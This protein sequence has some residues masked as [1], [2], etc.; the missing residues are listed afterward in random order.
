MNSSFASVTSADGS[1]SKRTTSSARRNRYSS[2]SVVPNA[3][4]TSAHYLFTLLLC[5]LSL[6]VAAVAIF[7]GVPVSIMLAPLVFIPLLVYFVITRV[8]FDIRIPLLYRGMCFLMKVFTLY[9]RCLPK[10]R[11]PMSPEM[12]AFE[13]VCKFNRPKFIKHFDL[14]TFR[15]Q[16]DGYRIVFYI[17]FSD[18]RAGVDIKSIEGVRCI[19]VSLRRPPVVGRE[20]VVLI[21]MHGGGFVAGCPDTFLGSVVPICHRIHRCTHAIFVDYRKAPEYP[22]PAAVDDAEVVYKACLKRFPAGTKFLFMGDSAGGA[23]VILTLLRLG[24]QQGLPKPVASVTFSPY[25][26]LTTSSDSWTRNNGL[27]FILEPR[28]IELAHGFSERVVRKNVDPKV[29]SPAHMTPAELSDLSPLYVSAS[30]HEPVIDE[31]QTFAAKAREAKVELVL[32]EVPHV[33]HVFSGFWMWAPESAASV[34]KIVKWVNERC[35]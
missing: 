2:L 6:P 22:L 28:I 9:A 29:F 31:I 17:P 4:I 11:C 19:D 27:D 3:A 25:V 1:S 13:L 14:Q 23:L 21:Y 34:D 33:P 26:D 18:L 35:A 10:S 5:I 16:L 8:A 15:A 7:I 32:E 24:A 12:K 30:L 20:P